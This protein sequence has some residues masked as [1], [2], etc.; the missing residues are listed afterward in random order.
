[1]DK[2]LEVQVEMLILATDREF[3][4]G[5]ILESVERTRKRYL[6]CEPG[7]DQETALE[8]MIKSA[9]LFMAYCRLTEDSEEMA[10]QPQIEADQPA[11][12]ASQTLAQEQYPQ[13]SGL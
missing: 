10:V 12:E 7:L 5:M 8:G 6:E 13:P 2:D 3:A 9:A 11:S 4:R 1:M